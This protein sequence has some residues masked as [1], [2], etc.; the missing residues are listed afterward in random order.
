MLIGILVLVLSVLLVWWSGRH[1]AVPPLA[2]S[3]IVDAE[4][5]VHAV[6]GVSATRS[7]E[8]TLNE[9]SEVVVSPIRLES[10]EVGMIVTMQTDEVGLIAKRL[11][12]APAGHLYLKSDNPE[13]GNWPY[14]PHDIR[15]YVSR[16][17]TDGEVFAWVAGE[18]YV[19]R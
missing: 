12:R 11:V 8:P 5:T 9:H 16:Y 17:E 19:R 4:G 6:L 2:S 18:G 1:E 15:G 7:M 14:R 10:L 13:M 3:V